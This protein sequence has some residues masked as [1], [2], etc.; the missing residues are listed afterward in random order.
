MTLS[1]GIC[2]H[3]SAAALTVVRPGPPFEK[4]IVSGLFF[5]MPLLLGMM[6]RCSHFRINLDLGEEGRLGS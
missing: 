4:F 1:I 5:T 2:P 3:D 6:C